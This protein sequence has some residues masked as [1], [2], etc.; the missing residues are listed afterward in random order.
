MSAN[1]SLIAA[2]ENRKLQQF[3]ITIRR[4]LGGC[5]LWMRSTGPDHRICNECKGKRERD[6][7]FAEWHAG[8]P[9]H[10]E[11]AS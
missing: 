1:H 8:Q 7:H 10:M 3:P 5:D 9:I 2:E 4:C 11:D 6:G